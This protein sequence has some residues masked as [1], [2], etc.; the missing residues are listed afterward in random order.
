[1]EKC[2]ECGG[3]IIRDLEGSHCSGCG[4]D[5]SEEDNF[6]TFSPRKELAMKNS[7]K[8]YSSGLLKDKKKLDYSESNPKILILKKI[9][10][11]WDLIEEVLPEEDTERIFEEFRDFIFN[12][13]KKKLARTRSKE[14]II[15]SV[16]ISFLDIES[17]DP[18]RLKGNNH[19]DK[20]KK[21]EKAKSILKN[22]NPEL[23]AKSQKF[24]GKQLAEDA[25]RINLSNTNECCLVMDWDIID[26]TWKNIKKRGL[27]KLFEKRQYPQ[28]INVIS[29]W[30][31]SL[32]KVAFDFAEK[33][34]RLRAQEMASRGKVP[35]TKKEIGL[36]CVSCYIVC[37]Y[38]PEKYCPLQQSEWAIFF[39]ISKRT[40]QNRYD[41]VMKFFNQKVQK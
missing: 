5:Y 34:L 41:E 17:K 2:I 12:L 19:E 24:R 29:E 18:K 1:M 33:Y 7:E 25:E 4:L 21:F 31:N 20:I 39:D 14:L 40:F 13:Y 22:S 9:K 11:I 3:A 10:K 38:N 28:P 27:Y 23:Y 37:K 8:Y 32:V 30:E 6:T 35:K 15:Y 36:I 26:P 16:L